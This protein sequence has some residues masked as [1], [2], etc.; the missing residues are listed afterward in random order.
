MR[1]AALLA[2]LPGA[3]CMA[4]FAHDQHAAH[5]HSP[6]PP[7]TQSTPAPAST[8]PHVDHAGTPPAPTAATPITPDPHAGHQV[9]APNKDPHAGH[10]MPMAGDDIPAQTA[11][12]ESL[13]VGDAPPPPVIKDNV[14]DQFYPPSS[15]SRARDI[16]NSEH[17][18]GLISKVMANIL[19]ATTSSGE[20]G[21]RWN[22][23]GRYGGDLNRFVFRTEGEA[24][25]GDVES[26]EVQGL[27]SRA[28]G[29][30]TDVQAGVRYDFEPNGVA[31]ATVGVETLLPYWFDVE[32]ALFVSEHGD[33]FARFE[34]SYDFQFTQRLILQP[35]LELTLAA[36][37]VP[38]SNIGSGFS[39]AEIGLR[40]RYDIRREFS[41][42]I[43]V[44]FEK[45]FGRT[46][47]LARASGDEADD[48]SVVL[49]LRAWF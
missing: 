44:N 37:D 42:Y 6:P 40:L 18:G 12:G 34:G 36:Q 46:A 33:T 16:L 48:I 23:E 32:G 17:G 26:G 7:P 41:P 8:D 24:P 49:G 3:L 14:S 11:S 1:K 47:D 22:I 2:L 38:E 5:K 30:Y 29:R 35:W 19:E 9:P 39:Q 43:G 45:R 28:I 27:Y 21:Y 20:E 10:A 31:Y 13:P 4:A 25:G 15:M